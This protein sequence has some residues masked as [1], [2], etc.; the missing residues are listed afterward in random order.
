MKKVGVLGAGAMGSRIA[1]NLLK[2]G[3]PVI[4]YNRTADK[5][6][7]LVNQ[8]AIYAATPREATEQ[9]DI[10]MSMMSDDD[11]SRQVWLDPATG[12]LQGL[13]KDTIA[14][15]SSTLTVE[16]TKTLATAIE[17]QGTDFLDVPIV[18]S[19]P[20]AEARKLIYLAGGKAEVLANIQPVLRSAGA[21]IVHH[22]GSVGQGMA[23][24]L[25]VNALF[26]IQV[27]ALAELIG[28]LDKQGIVPEKAMDCLGEL[29]VTS[30]AAKG[31]GSLMVANYHAPMFPINLIEKDFRYVVQTAQ[32]INAAIPASTSI[33]PIYQD[34]IAQG[35]G[36]QNITGIVQLFI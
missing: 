36:D 23:M 35:Y 22:I 13:R 6:Q 8:G 3:Y 25:A 26:G 30:L 34:A 9:V 14:L 29:P 17:R 24:K 27:A 16:W 5:V 11:V 19:R 4:V 33:H 20:Q 21:V 1:Q 12:A 7:S 2:A 15:E 32:A 18:G 28:M 31:A 10:V